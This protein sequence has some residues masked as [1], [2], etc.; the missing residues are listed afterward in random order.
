MNRY[1]KV[2][3]H[4]D[5]VS[6]IVSSYKDEVGFVVGKLVSVSLLESEITLRIDTA[7]QSWVDNDPNAWAKMFREWCEKYRLTCKAWEGDD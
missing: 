5:N 3:G 1:F 6:L 7:H 4:N 2:R